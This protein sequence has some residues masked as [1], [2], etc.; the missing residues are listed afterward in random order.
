MARYF[1]DV[2][3][4]MT[5]DNGLEFE[6]LSRMEALGTMVYFTQ[7]YNSWERAQNEGHNGLLLSS[8]TNLSETRKR[9]A[10]NIN[11]SI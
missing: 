7:P 11:A 1:K 5:A 2:F 8:S 9:N 4:T 10:A 6:T 3:K